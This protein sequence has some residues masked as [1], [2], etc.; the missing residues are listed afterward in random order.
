MHPRVQTKNSTTGNYLVMPAEF[1]IEYY[2]K[3]QQNT[4]IN[5][6]ATCVLERLDVNYTPHEFWAAF[7]KTGFPPHILLRMLFKEVE[8]LHREMIKDD[9]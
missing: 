6:I 7:D 4:S 9:Y 1:D 3:D 5:K 8:P 2:Y